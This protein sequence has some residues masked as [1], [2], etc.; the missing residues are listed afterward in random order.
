MVLRTIIFVNQLS[1][2]GAVADMCDEL[3]CRI[4]GCSERTGKLGAQDNP[5][6]TVILTE[7]TTLNKS[8][9]ADDNVQRK[10][11]QNCDQ[12]FA[13]LPETSSIDQTVHQCRTH[14]DRDEGTV[15]HDSRRCG[16][17]QIGRLMSRELLVRDN[18]VSK[19]KGCIRGNTKI[20]PALEVAVSHHQGRY[21]IEIMI[22]SLF[23]DG[24]CS[25]VMIVNGI[26][27]YVTEMTEETQDDHID[28]IGESTRKPV[29]KARPKQTTISMT[30]STTTLPY[31]LRVWID[32]E[33]G[34][35]DKSCSE[36][37]ENLIAST[38][39]FSTSTRRR[40]GRI[41]ILV[42]DVSFRIN[43]FSALVSSN[44]AG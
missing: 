7:L 8:P 5:E 22:E 3:D 15:F 25:W 6:T 35:Y 11:L 44:I 16:T 41:Q 4:S 12:K 29:A 18:A 27:K 42:T 26:N 2:Y 31:H 21:G 17:G 43:V 39:S 14:E 1:I 38:W 19:V 33:P 34:P 28:Y 30:S 9:R 24:T 20:G 40:S 13:H 36:V 10:L 23:D 37:S 32:A